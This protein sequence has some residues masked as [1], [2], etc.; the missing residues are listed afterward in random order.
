MEM[1]SIIVLAA[2]LSRR[3]GAENKLLLSFQGQT[4]LETTVSNILEAEIG[5]VIVVVG[6]EAEYVKKVLNNRFSDLKI[7]E[8]PDFELGMTTSIKAGIRA[9]QENT[10]GYMICLSDMLLIEPNEYQF[11][12]NQF[13]DFYKQNKK[14]IVQPIFEEKRG[15]PVIFSRFYQ[16]DILETTDTEGCRSVVQKYKNHVKLIEMTTNHILQDVD[17]KE[18]YEKLVTAKPYE[19]SKP[20]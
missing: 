2:G 17:F 15:N 8:N 6:H 20:S 5:E 4:I 18:D 16:K 7:V 19:G 11:L 13:L 1:L 12:A 9:A 10:E 14:V 3:M